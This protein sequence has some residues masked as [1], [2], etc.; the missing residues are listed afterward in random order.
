M[1]LFERK[2]E[3]GK[4]A[5]IREIRIS[6][7]WTWFGLIHSTAS[8][9]GH[10]P[11]PAWTDWNKAGG[12]NAGTPRTKAGYIWTVWTEN[13]S[14]QRTLVLKEGSTDFDKRLR[15]KNLLRIWLRIKKGIVGKNIYFV[16]VLPI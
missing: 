6:V 10:R 1:T 15:G 3:M 14:Y 9:S 2:G 16:W 8:H 13:N 12:W 4:K 7:Y 5:S 11:E